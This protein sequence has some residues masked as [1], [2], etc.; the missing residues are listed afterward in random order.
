[1]VCKMHTI[2]AFDFA[3]NEN[4]VIFDIRE[5]LPRY[6]SF[7]STSQTATTTTCNHS[8]RMNTQNKRQHEVDGSGCLLIK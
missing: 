5:W 7:V 8:Y 2:R 3:N 1:M 4:D 6:L